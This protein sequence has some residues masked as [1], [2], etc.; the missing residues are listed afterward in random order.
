MTTRGSFHISRN[1]FDQSRRHGSEWRLI[2]VVFSSTAL[3]SD[4]ISSAQVDDVLE[5]S[6]DALVAAV[7][8]DTSEFRWTESAFVTPPSS[9]WTQSSIA[10][11]PTFITPG[12]RG[13]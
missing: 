7:T 13:R 3:V 5:L 10:L 1:E 12:I 6:S 4:E 8:P 9:S 2:Q 11:D